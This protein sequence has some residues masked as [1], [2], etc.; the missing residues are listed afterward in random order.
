MKKLKIKQV[1][2]Q[3]RHYSTLFYVTF[4]GYSDVFYFYPI[5]TFV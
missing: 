1:V 4:V 5:P 2:A 3:F